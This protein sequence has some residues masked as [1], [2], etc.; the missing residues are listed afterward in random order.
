MS[1]FPAWDKELQLVHVCNITVKNRAVQGNHSRSCAGML[2]PER[3]CSYWSRDSR[4]SRCWA[5]TP[6]ASLLQQR[7]VQLKEECTARWLELVFS[8]P[9][10][11]SL[12]Q[13]VQS[14]PNCL[15]HQLIHKNT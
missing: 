8:S 3:V 9:Q 15:A 7:P 5:S 13:H 1:N 6:A 12:V 11:Q 10:E 2:E 14:L 4:H